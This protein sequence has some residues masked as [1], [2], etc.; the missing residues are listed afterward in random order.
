MRAAIL[1][2]YRYSI[3]FAVRYGTFVRPLYAI[4]KCGI[5]SVLRTMDSSHD[6]H[7]YI[8]NVATFSERYAHKVEQVKLVKRKIEVLNQKYT[9]KT[10]F[11]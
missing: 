9:N 3:N 5:D 4:T 8:N 6:R 1:L 7:R 2:R 11:M 10:L